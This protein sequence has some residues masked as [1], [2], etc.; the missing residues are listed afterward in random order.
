MTKLLWYAALGPWRHRVVRLNIVGA[1]HW[2]PPRNGSC[3]GQLVRQLL[4]ALTVREE[5][6]NEPHNDAQVS[7]ACNW[8]LIRAAILLY[9]SWCCRWCSNTSLA[10][11]SKWSTYLLTDFANHEWLTDCGS[12]WNIAFLVM[13]QF[14]M[15]KYTLMLLANVQIL[16]IQLLL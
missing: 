1:M 3:K 14:A 9:Y 15:T 13:H 6:R 16:P 4:H 10:L 11:L 7:C 2:P 5:L 12:N 8:T